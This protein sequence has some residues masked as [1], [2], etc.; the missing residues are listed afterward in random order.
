[1]SEKGAN[2]MIQLLAIVFVL[3]I[4]FPTKGEKAKAKQQRRPW[5]DIRYDD[6]IEYDIFDDD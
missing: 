4:L 3:L 5:Y 1:M 6:I 2:F